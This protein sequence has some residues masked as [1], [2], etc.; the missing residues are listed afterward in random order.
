MAAF[1]QIYIYMLLYMYVCIMEYKH[2]SLAVSTVSL[3]EEM[4]STE[5]LIF[6]LQHLLSFFTY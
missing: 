5:L 6:P 4:G 1:E 3:F 2:T